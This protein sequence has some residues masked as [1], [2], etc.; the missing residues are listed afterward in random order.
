MENIKY[1]D[2]IKLT[3]SVDRC[4]RGANKGLIEMQKQKGYETLM[5]MAVDDKKFM[6]RTMGSQKDF[7]YADA[8]IDQT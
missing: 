5:Q 7:A 1:L 2:E 3:L 6:R 8:D 4:T